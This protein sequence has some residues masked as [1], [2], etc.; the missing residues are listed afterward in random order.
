MPFAKGVK[1]PA[2]ML[3]RGW[4]LQG[5]VVL[6]TGSPFDIT[7]SAARSNTGGGDRPNVV[8]DPTTGFQQSIYQWFNTAA[9]ASQ[10]LYSY[11][12]LGRNVLR[13]THSWQADLALQRSFA[14]TERLRLE[15]RGE[16]F[17]VLNHPNFGPP[18]VTLGASNFGIP[19]TTLNGALLGVS[20]LYQI[21]GPRSLQFALKLRF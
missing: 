9:F 10:P 2:A 7:N 12:N 6:T 17:N 18:N 15:A 3:A 1:G 13:G 20:S 11:G 16:A 19:T 8:G 14:L 4:A 5:V 21:G